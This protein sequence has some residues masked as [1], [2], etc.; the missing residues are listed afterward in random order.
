MGNTLNTNE[1]MSTLKKCKRKLNKKRLGHT[2]TNRFIVQYIQT[3][4]KSIKSESRIELDSLDIRRIVF[5]SLFGFYHTWKRCP[6]HI[7]YTCLLLMPLKRKWI[8]SPSKYRHELPSYLRATKE[9]DL[10]IQLLKWKDQQGLVVWTLDAIDADTHEPS[11]SLI[12]PVWSRLSHTLSHLYDPITGSQYNGINFNEQW[13]Q[14]TLKTNGKYQVTPS[15]LLTEL[16]FAPLK[17]RSVQEIIHQS[18]P[19]SLIPLVSYTEYS[20]KTA[21]PKNDS[22]QN[23]LYEDFDEDD[24]IDNWW[25]SDEYD[26]SQ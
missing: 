22:F 4:Q 9:T 5:V 25:I 23:H 3:V 14:N 7:L 16:Y 13:W 10:F 26:P 11:A 12:N 1:E 20:I 18:N 6:L 17:Y 21:D 19:K 8:Y 15:V 24:E 2:D